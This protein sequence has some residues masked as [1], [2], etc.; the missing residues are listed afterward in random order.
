MTDQKHHDEHDHAPSTCEGLGKLA[1]KVANQEG[2][3]WVLGLVLVVALGALFTLQITANSYNNKAI[4]AI[5]M[6]SAKTSESSHQ[7]NVIFSAYIAADTE[8]SNQMAARLER[9]EDEIQDHRTR[10]DR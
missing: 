7:M 8:R 3:W 9:I 1:T 2:R 6:S 5:Q 4:S 10:T